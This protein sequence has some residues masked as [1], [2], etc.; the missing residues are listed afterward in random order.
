MKLLG[1]ITDSSRDLTGS[2]RY[3]GTSAPGHFSL[4]SRLDYQSIKPRSSEK[5]S[6][7]SPFRH[8]SGTVGTNFGVRPF[9]RGHYGSQLFKTPK[10][11]EGRGGTLESLSRKVPGFDDRSRTL[12]PGLGLGSGSRFG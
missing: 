6:S 1:A 10:K 7:K 9:N 3:E 11:E 12:P 5:E 2:S 8:R 4:S